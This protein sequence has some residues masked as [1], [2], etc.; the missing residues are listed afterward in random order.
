MTHIRFFTLREM[1]R[2]FEQ[3]GFDIEM[4]AVLSRTQPPDIPQFPAEVRLRGGKFALTVSSP[5]EWL[6]LHAGQFGF[7]LRPAPRAR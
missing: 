6:V 4:Q 3:T 5:E 1:Q 7:R 2:M